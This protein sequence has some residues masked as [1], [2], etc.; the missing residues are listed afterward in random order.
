VNL[1]THQWFAG[2]L[3]IAGAWDFCWWVRRRFV[4]TNTYKQAYLMAGKLNRPL[5]VV[6]APDGGV[7]A[8][9]GC[10]DIVVDI[11]ETALCPISIKADITKK[12]PMKDD[13]AVVFVSCVLEYVD[14][15]DAAMCELLRVAGSRDKLFIVRVE[16]W[17]AT[18]YLYPGAK[19]VIT[20]DYL[21]GK[22]K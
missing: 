14:D 20:S 11:K 12:L 19:R 4:R 15:L 8:G 5:V 17:T 10:G 22:C 2:I 13:S 3:G 21:P 18:A 9:Y 16:P 1:S 6:G 7:T